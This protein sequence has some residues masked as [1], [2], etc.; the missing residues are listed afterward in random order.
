MIFVDEVTIDVSAGSGGNGAVAFRKEK[1]VPHGGPAG[2]DGGKGGDI[3][4]LADSNLSTL[5]DFRYQRLYAAKKG[6]DGAAKDMY[7]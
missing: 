7:G 4:L 1:Y 5:L 2:G 3:I 6:V